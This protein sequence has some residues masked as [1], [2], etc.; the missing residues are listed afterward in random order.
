MKYRYLGDSG[1]A[2]S[3]ISLGTMTF[4]MEGWGCDEQTSIEITQEFLNAGGNLIDTADMYS[5]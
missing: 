3:C 2:V 4:G 1:M 5:M